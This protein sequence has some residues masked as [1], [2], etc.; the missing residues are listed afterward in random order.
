MTI[1]EHN[2]SQQ[3]LPRV[4]DSS[5]LNLEKKRFHL[6]RETSFSG[7]KSNRT[8]LPQLQKF[9]EIKIEY[10]HKYFF[11]SRFFRNARNHHCTNLR[12]ALLSWSSST[13]VP[14]TKLWKTALF[15]LQKIFSPAFSHKWN[16]K[17][18]KKFNSFHLSL[19]FDLDL[20][21]LVSFIYLLL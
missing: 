13:L 20:R 9:S 15:H 6:H 5:L 3:E 12:F 21:L 14:T 2:K 10:P 17:R 18:F 7:E 19:S 8:V 1:R 11:Y 4:N 16:W